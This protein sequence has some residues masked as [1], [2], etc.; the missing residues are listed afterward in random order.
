MSGVEYDGGSSCLLG[1]CDLF[2][3]PRNCT[4]LPT[5]Y[6]SITD[7]LRAIIRFRLGRLFDIFRQRGGNLPPPHTIAFDGATRVE[8]LYHGSAAVAQASRRVWMDDF[9]RDPPMNRPLASR[10]R[11][12]A[13]RSIRRSGA[14]VG[15]T[16]VYV[17]IH[18]LLAETS[19]ET[20]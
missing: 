13:N 14:I 2:P 5:T 8:R 4:I 11:C 17:T 20:W 3:Y 15:S 18:L 7:Q 10:S 12:L 6:L 1:G 9:R 19:S 16:A